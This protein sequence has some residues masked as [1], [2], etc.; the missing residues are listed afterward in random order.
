L[1]ELIPVNIKSI[2]LPVVQNK[3]KESTWEKSTDQ[4]IIFDS[5]FQQNDQI[6]NKIL[7]ENISKEKPILAQ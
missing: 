3:V 2:E 5:K 6:N 1:I 7:E 4:L